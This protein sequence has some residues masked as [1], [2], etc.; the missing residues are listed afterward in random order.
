MDERR[1]DERLVDQRVVDERSLDERRRR[2]V[3]RVGRTPLPPLAKLYYFLLVG[4]ALVC[5]LVSSRHA[6]PDTRG[7]VTF[8]VL[9]AAAAAA[10]VFTVRTGNSHGFHTAIVFLVAGAVLLPP[11]LVALMA[12]VQ[13]VPEWFTERYPWYIQ[14]FNITNHVLDA[15]AAWGVAA[16]VVD[17]PVLDEPARFAVG[18]IAACFVFVGLNHTLLAGMLRAAKRLSF[19]ASGLFTVQSL[20][21]DL[22]L[23]FL[24]V[25]LALLWLENAYVIP[26][27]LAPIFLTHRS[28]AFLGRMRDSDER[29]RT[30]FDSAVVG[31]AFRDL[32]GRL[33]SCNPALERMLGRTEAELSAL[34]RDAYAHAD[35]LAHER[36]LFAE[37]VAGTRD[38]YRL[39]ERLLAADGS[40]VSA[41]VVASL[42]HDAGERP[43]FVLEMLEDCTE[44]K[45][46]EA[47]LRQAQKMEGVGQLAGGVAHDF[48]NLL[49]AI[50]GYS[51]LALQS[52]QHGDRLATTEVQGIRQAAEQAATLTRQLLAFSRKQI[53][54]PKVLDLN[55]V[56]DAVDTLLRRLIAEDVEIRASLADGLGRVKADPGQLEQVLINLAVN[57]RDA[58]PSGGTLAIETANLELA[59][60]EA[61]VPSGRYV[62]LTVRDTGDGMDAETRA[63]VFEPFF[64][65][66]EQGKGTGLGLSTVYGI[67][68]QSGG[69][70]TVDSD[71]G[72]GT[73]FRIY[74]TRVDEPARRRPIQNVDGSLAP[75][76]S[77]T[78]LLVED[79]EVVRRLIR[80]I[81]ERS[82]YRVLEAPDGAGAL[83]VASGQAQAIDLLL[84]DV[85]MPKMKGPEL[86]ER[87]ATI[88][89]GAKVLF[90]SGYTDDRIVEDGALT[91]GTAFL[92]K[93]FNPGGLAQKVREVLDA[94]S[95]RAA[96]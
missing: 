11:Q 94:S 50:V 14:S 86:A 92:Q 93:P 29:F 51:D 19:R 4:C 69:F 75:D 70:I 88:S 66:K 76:G 3:N 12:I 6:A 90:M 33:V 13:H 81:L 28:F 89:P 30:M 20:A 65:T 54:Q 34:D 58:M 9:A 8:L 67:V 1:L 96:A 31:I 52:M 84:T 22:V 26:A 95:A 56:V 25:V 15:L 79:E 2:A 73:T 5:G 59:A 91:P 47:D 82:G 27:L 53:L 17:G 55:E 63:R 23:A 24:G 49:T 64:T 78:I 74:L 68:K 72:A 44:R 80:E 21:I 45:K 85:V 41:G 42:V 87:L 39:E 71:P 16:L 77:E 7:W 57:A 61:P 62:V 48:N 38:E 36:G 40:T 46:L 10:Q 60:D 43:Q 37:I 18:G 35:D 32:E 83:E